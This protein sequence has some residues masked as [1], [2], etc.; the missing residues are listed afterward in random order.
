M[1]TCNCQS[2]G[3]NL[4]G[5][6]NV[7]P[8]T[9][10]KHNQQDRL[11]QMKTAQA[12]SDRAIQ[13]EIDDITRFLSQITLNSPPS[14]E[15]DSQNSESDSL[16]RRTIIQNLLARLG[17]IEAKVVTLESDVSSALVHSPPSLTGT[18]PFPLRPLVA[19]ALQLQR[20]L[21]K[22]MHKAHSIVAM[23]SSICKRVSDI[24]ERLKLAKSEWLEKQQKLNAT[25]GARP[26][27]PYSTGIT[28]FLP[29]YRF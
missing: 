22:V 8:T 23:K 17:E 14:S 18:T 9:L 11:T 20:D 10:R 16:S 6:A 3:C 27:S 5:G 13:T 12:E 24:H 25:T 26:G 2:Y 15:S 21:D 1:P 29:S 7:S 19:Q 4:R 28:F